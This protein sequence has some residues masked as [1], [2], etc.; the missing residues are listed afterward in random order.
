MSR[1]FTPNVY[2]GNDAHIVIMRH[3]QQIT[4]TAT[5]K[6]AAE[7]LVWTANYCHIVKDQIEL[8]DKH[9]ES[10]TNMKEAVLTAECMGALKVLSGDLA[11][12]H[13]MVMEQFTKENEGV[14]VAGSLPLKEDPDNKGDAKEYL[15][16]VAMRLIE[17]QG[18]KPEEIS[19]EDKEELEAEAKADELVDKIV[20]QH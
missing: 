13:A 3:V 16:K 10:L 4:D 5:E 11:R 2:F 20:D 12:L 7:M 15:M 1:H 8:A 19:D 9:L 14:R 6:T 17:A 18:M